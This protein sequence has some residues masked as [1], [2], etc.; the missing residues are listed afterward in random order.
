MGGLL[1]L[2][3]G[4]AD[5]PVEADEFAVDGRQRTTARI[6]SVRL[7]RTEA[8]SLRLGPTDTG[9]FASVFVGDDL[10]AAKRTRT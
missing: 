3:D 6:N 5:V 4:A 10:L 7:V 8:Y 9:R 2:D 1:L